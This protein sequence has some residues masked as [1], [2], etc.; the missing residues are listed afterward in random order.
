MEIVK[1]ILF[2]LSHS[3]KTTSHCYFSLTVH[4]CLRIFCDYVH[5]R[6]SYNTHTHNYMKVNWF[7]QNLLSG[8]L[9]ELLNLLKCILYIRTLGL[10]C[11]QTGKCTHL[12]K[13][14]WEPLHKAVA[15][16]LSPF[17]KLLRSG[18]QRIW[19]SRGPSD[20]GM[21]GAP[22]CKVAF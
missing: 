20:Y 17:P 12:Y 11:P 5:P 8:V 21:I 9:N 18:F 2:L 1:E 15:D 14:Y 16:K 22:V 6:L 4:R 19:G 3:W 10:T 13:S 7:R